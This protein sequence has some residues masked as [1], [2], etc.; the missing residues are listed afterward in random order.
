MEPLCLA[1]LVYY[2]HLSGKEY[3][4]ANTEHIQEE[5]LFTINWRNDVTIA[6][7]MRY[8]SVLWDITRVDMFE[9]YKVD[10]SVYCKLR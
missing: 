5:V 9:G 1:E 7:A 2:R 4:A 10:I 8:N 3:H 6:H